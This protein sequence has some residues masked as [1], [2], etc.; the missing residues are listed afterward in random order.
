ML[1]EVKSGR[2]LKKC[3]NI[4]PNLQDI[5]PDVGEEYD[6]NKN[7]KTLRAE[8][9]I[10]HLTTFQQSVITAFVKKYW[11]VFSKKEVTKP[12]KD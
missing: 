2:L 8:L 1:P 3:N 6:E 11:R 7:G 10:A 9:A 4:S 12:F 5:D